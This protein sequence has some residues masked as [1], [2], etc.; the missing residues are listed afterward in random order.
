MPKRSK[1][2]IEKF[3][4]TM[5]AKRN[6]VKHSEPIE[7]GPPRYILYQGHIYRRTN[8]M[9]GVKVLR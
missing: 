2:A 6:Q 4:A 1:E 3:K 7:E 8:H 9:P 5:A